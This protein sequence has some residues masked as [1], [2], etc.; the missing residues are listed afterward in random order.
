MHP[1]F[2]PKLTSGLCST[3]YLCTLRSRRTT[4]LACYGVRLHAQ[5][6]PGLEL[7]EAAPGLAKLASPLR[8]LGEKP[9]NAQALALAAGAQVV[10]AA[11]VVAVHLNGGCA[12]KD[13]WL[14]PCTAHSCSLCLALCSTAYASSFLL[15]QRN[16]LLSPSVFHLAISCHPSKNK[17]PVAA[18]IPLPW[19]K[20]R[21]SCRTTPLDCRT[22]PLIAQS[23]TGS[24]WARKRTCH[25]ESEMP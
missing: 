5:R 8:R 13:F 22:A 18:F 6:A 16:C 14:S 1:R 7:E 10:D 3:T 12:N 9:R 11:R 15:L 21:R 23:R 19:V 4:E 25:E 24:S 17:I 20:F 2:L